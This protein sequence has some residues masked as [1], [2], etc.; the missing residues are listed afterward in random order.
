MPWQTFSRLAQRSVPQSIAS[1]KGAGIS[2]CGGDVV[3]VLVGEDEVEGRAVAVGFL[4]AADDDLVL[5]DEVAGLGAEAA[6]EAE[7]EFGVELDGE[8]VD[9]VAVDQR[10]DEVGDPLR[11]G[12]VAALRAGGGDRDRDRRSRCRR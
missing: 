10:A 3:P 4:V 9:L 6:V 7:L 1:P 8:Q 12:H 2:R 11:V 5:A